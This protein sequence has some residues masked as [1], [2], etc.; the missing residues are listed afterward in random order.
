VNLVEN[1]ERKN[2]LLEIGKGGGDFEIN[3]HLI[4]ESGKG[5]LKVKMANWFL[6]KSQF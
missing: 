6:E 4:F 1:F 5:A 3:L 2:F